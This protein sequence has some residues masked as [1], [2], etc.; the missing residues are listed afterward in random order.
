ML[1]RLRLIELR[2]ERPK[3]AATGVGR[4]R[5]AAMGAGRP[6][7]IVTGA[8]RPEEVATIEVGGLA[9]LSSPAFLLLLAFSLLSTFWPLNK[10]LFRLF[11]K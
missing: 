3:K 8:K 4:L 10:L 2:V 5:K 6:I 7:E 9:S 11:D 1:T